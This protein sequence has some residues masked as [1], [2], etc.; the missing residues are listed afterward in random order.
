MTITIG[1][2]SN[3]LVDVPEKVPV[4]RIYSWVDFFLDSRRR[5]LCDVSKRL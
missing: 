2:A 3:M 5:N 4:P 1:Q